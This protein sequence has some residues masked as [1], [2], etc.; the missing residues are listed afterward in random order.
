MKGEESRT[1]SNLKQIE[2]VFCVINEGTQR[3]A[4]LTSLEVKSGSDMKTVVDREGI[5]SC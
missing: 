2:M 5:L 1:C 3:K 4:V